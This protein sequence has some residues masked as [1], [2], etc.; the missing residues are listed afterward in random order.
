MT[1]SLEGRRRAGEKKRAMT[2]ARVLHAAAQLFAEKG[3]D[4]VPVRAI[5]ERAYVGTSTIA[6]IFPAPTKARLLLE[7]PSGV[8]S[9]LP[10]GV[11]DD[12]VRA[13]NERDKAND[14]VGRGSIRWL[15]TRANGGSE[16]T[17][18]EYCQ[19]LEEAL[20][21]LD[22]EGASDLRTH[23]LMEAGRAWVSWGH[24]REARDYRRSSEF[25]ERAV[26]EA[27]H[28]G[29]VLLQAQALRE[30]IRTRMHSHTS[31]HERERDAHLGE[32][33]GDHYALRKR[34]GLK[35]V[36]EVDAVRLLAK[37]H[38]M[39]QEHKLLLQRCQE[40]LDLGRS[41]N[42]L[43][44]ATDAVCTSAALRLWF[45][46]EVDQAKTLLRELDP[47]DSSLSLDMRNRIR[48]GL[49]ICAS[50]D[51]DLESAWEYLD[52]VKYA[53]SMNLSV[54][55]E[56]V[57]VEWRLGRHSRAVRNWRRA[58]ASYGYWVSCYGSLTTLFESRYSRVAERMP[59]TE[60]L[61]EPR[62]IDEEAI[63]RFRQDAEELLD[64]I[65]AGSDV[66]I[67]PDLHNLI[68]ELDRRL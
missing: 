4:D 29:D 59:S 25:L 42:D 40:L 28:L 36:A 7:L 65:D 56:L 20:A 48:Y 6:A 18:Q 50:H 61:D 23:C 15:L 33:I 13:V 30:L 62:A 19:Q 54:L 11:L 34:L 37:W 55:V 24:P 14:P 53:E 60:L 35:D 46:I 41:T 63:E 67:P 43:E 38:G 9:D 12:A 44:T 52:S 5:A 17:S 31:S 49:G 66:G 27:E 32:L 21:L 39:Q 64:A 8:R 26:R 58:Q 45:G 68:R 47:N 16:G 1:G 10:E 51:G 22:T 2:K 3:V 57:D